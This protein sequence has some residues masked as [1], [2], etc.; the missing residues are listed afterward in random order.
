LLHKIEGTNFTGSLLV[1]HS[2]TGTLSSAENNTGVGINSLKSITSGDANIGLGGRTGFNL[3]TGSRN[4]LVGYRTGENITTGSFNIAIGDEALFTEDENGKNIALG[5]HALR[6]QDAGADAFNVAIGHQAGKTIS[7]GTNNVIIGG[8]AGDA[9]L[10]G[11]NNVAIGKSA[12]SAETDGSKNVAVGVNAL[13]VANGGNSNVALG[14]HAGV[15]VSTGDQNTMV[16]TNAGDAVTT[17]SNNTII[18]FDAAASAVDVSNE[19]TIGNSSV[20]NV[21]IPSDS[22]LKIGASGDLQLEHV[23]SNSFIKNTAVGDLYIENQVDDADVIFRCDDGSGGVTTYFELDGN[24][25]LNKFRQNLYLLD[26]VGLKIG[27]SFD[28]DIK[29]DGSDSYIQ[30]ATGDL[31]I[32][33]TSDNKDIILQSDNGSGGVIEY[34]R[35]DGSDERLTVNAPNG[36]LFFDNIKAKFGTS[37]DFTIH[38]NGTVSA[39]NNAL[40]HIQIFQNANDSN[41]EF[42]SDDG[43]GGVAE[44]FR[45]DGSE[46][47]V[48][49]FKPT[50]HGDN[51]K[52][53][54]GDSGDLQ[55]F[56]NGTNSIIQNITGD[57]VI[58]N[59]LDDKDI[60]FKSD[61]GSGGITEYFRVDG[62]TGD[63]RFSKNTRHLNNVRAEFGSSGN[64]II[65]HDGDDT[66]LQCGSSGGNLTLQVAEDDHDMIFQCDDG[67]GG[68]TE[69]FRLDGGLAN[70]GTVHTVF[71]DNSRATF[72]NGFDL[73]IY[74][75]ATNSYIK[76]GAG[77][78]LI[79]QQETDD[80]NIIFKS[81]DGSG[82]LA[83]YFKIDG[84]FEVNKFSKN[85]QFLDNVLAMFGNGAD[86][87]I[88]S[89][90]S[91]GLINNLVGNLTI[92]TSTDDG[93]IIFKS[94]N[95][96]GG[97]M[98][99]FRLDGSD[100]RININARMQFMDN[101]QAS[102]GTSGDL[103]IQH[104][105]T[106]SLITNA[107][108]NL[109]IQQNADDADISFQC[110]DGSGS[111]TEYFRLDGSSVQ[112]IV[113]K[114]FRYVDNAKILIGTG[115]DLHIYHDGT[116]S[117][118]E[119]ST[120][121]IKFTNKADDQDIL[122]QSD[123][124]NGGVTTYFKCDGV[125]VRTKFLT[126]TLITDN[127]KIKVGS[128]GDLEIY[129]DGSN[130]YVQADGTGDLIIKQ[131][132][133]DKDIKFMCDDGSGGTEIYI[134]VDGSARATK[135]VNSTFH[136]DNVQGKFGNAGDMV[137]YH[138]GT[139]NLIDSVA[140]DISIRQLDNDKDIRLRCDDGSGGETDYILLDGSEVSTKIL[141]QKVIMS[142]LPTSDPSNAGQLYNDSGVLKV[143][144]G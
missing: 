129:H 119:N 108:G 45:V 61:D 55:I 131:N 48:R 84:Q 31:Y 140:G 93:D 94:D 125:N 50:E 105:G 124:G 122:F 33:N 83:E 18:G 89:N 114:N 4:V 54:F 103:S 7:T 99:Y 9:L 62:G 40:G 77:G 81:D 8:L 49:F 35:L 128:G 27:N 43:S 86:L 123:S 76:Q 36:M 96:S 25:V 11:N 102:F 88:S 53:R 29:H 107:N 91:S 10:D 5:Y 112:T 20:A 41:I 134:N 51:V 47:Q 97:L 37:S 46:E 34:L 137:I 127:K 115:E 117:I 144:A 64:F 141:T 42:Y 19:V 15:S 60:V 65:K 30:N 85:V 72:G 2:T 22:T 95:G 70:S 120:G 58:Q 132:T 80:G 139:N 24:N 106:S 69:Y 56:H 39:I 118:I 23:S 12:L 68:T 142:N 73:Q 110:D 78:D 66:L 130:S 98:D 6:A 116:N 136:N 17:G 100:T 52:A 32:K 75:D 92:Q 126:D 71:P 79:I 143:S 63:T 67:S 59:N 57:L 26:N 109:N 138:N 111:L 113:T 101:V 74:H 3:T 133:D 82:G 21:R 121:D 1:G 104:D 14:R 28:L 13:Q 87:T 90:G 44:Y 135:F 16:G 38:H